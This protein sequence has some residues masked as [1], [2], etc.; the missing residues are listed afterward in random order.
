MPGWEPGGGGDASVGGHLART[1]SLH[2]SKALAVTAPPKKAKKLWD[3]DRK[4]PMKLPIRSE[5]A[6]VCSTC[7]LRNPVMSYTC[8]ACGAPRPGGLRRK[9]ERV[10]HGFDEED[11]QKERA[12]EF[13]R[14]AEVEA[15][16]ALIVK[17]VQGKHGWVVTEGGSVRQKGAFLP[18]ATVGASD[19]VANATTNFPTTVRA[20]GTR[21][22]RDVA[23]WRRMLATMAANG[24]EIEGHDPRVVRRF[25]KGGG[26]KRQAAV[27][28]V[29]YCAFDPTHD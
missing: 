17:Q 16:K 13:A 23:M 3:E 14:L 18:S 27:L 11:H 28:P 25:N 4:D 8:M 7:T 6:W 5:T 24:G 9:G 15:K 12:A 10:S 2:R 19:S 1:K 29:L 22:A 26:A 20:D 21:S